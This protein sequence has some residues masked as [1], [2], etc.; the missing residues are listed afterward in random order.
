MTTNKQNKLVSG[1]N[2]KTVNNTSLLGSG[3]VAVQP[4]LVSGTNIKKINNQSLLGS[5]NLNI[6]YADLWDRP[7]W[8]GTGYN[9][10]VHLGTGSKLPSGEDAEDLDGAVAHGSC[11]FDTAVVQIEGLNIYAAAPGA[12][13]EGIICSDDDWRAIDAVKQTLSGSGIHALGEGSHAEGTAYIESTDTAPRGIYATGRGAHA[14]GR[15]TLGSSS[16]TASGVGAHAEGEGTTA[17]GVAS[18][19]EGR[20]TIAQNNYE[21]SQGQFNVSNKASYIW[22]NAGNTLFNI[23]IGTSDSTRKNAFEVM[24]NGDIYLY[25]IGTY[26]GT[27]PTSGVNDIVTTINQKQSKSANSSVPSGGFLPDEFY[28]LG[29]LTGTISFTLATAVA[30]NINHYFWTFETSTTAPTVTWPT[31][32]TWMGGNS[33]TIVANKHYEIS[34]L[35]NIAV[36]MEV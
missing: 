14:E 30:G 7:W 18:H 10:A 6:T 2:I 27:N 13:A 4:T 22:G 9:W 21:H 8:T 32:I 19:A 11:Y 15:T 1:T 34:I 17:E 36:Y 28:S 3:N 33:P 31:G 20:E 16:I 23:G 24:Q 12:H 5:G 26:D 35:N 25:G 29:T